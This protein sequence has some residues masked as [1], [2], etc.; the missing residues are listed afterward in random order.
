M[1]LKDSLI[2]TQ[3]EQCLK[4]AIEIITKDRNNSY[5]G[6]EDSF[7]DIA[8]LWNTYLQVK[9]KKLLT[10]LAQD[11][12]GVLSLPTLEAHDVALMM[13]LMKTAR[14]VSNPSHYDS[15]VDKAGYAG[16]GAEVAP[17]IPKAGKETIFEIAGRAAT[18]ESSLS[19]PH[20]WVPIKDD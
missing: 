20:N 14:L 1:S 3:R 15:W 7:N 2:A 8:A 17:L 16:C 10:T 4:E 18:L 13:D 19:K 5:G 12:V 9:A 11:K 6:P